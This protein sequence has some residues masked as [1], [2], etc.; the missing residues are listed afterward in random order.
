MYDNVL[1]TVLTKLDSFN[2]FMSSMLVHNL[3]NFNLLAYLYVPSVNFFNWLLSSGASRVRMMP[4]IA[5]RNIRPGKRELP[6]L[7]SRFLLLLF[8]LLLRFESFCV[9][10]HAPLVGYAPLN[11]VPSCANLV[12]VIQLS[13][14]LNTSLFS[15]T[16]VRPVIYLSTK[17]TPHY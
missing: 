10:L 6:L 15:L 11:L 1:I 5:Q 3:C 12:I 16:P 2:S 4:S 7:V 8:D 13:V 14:V 9:D 17:Y